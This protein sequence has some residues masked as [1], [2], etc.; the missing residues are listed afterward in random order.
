VAPK[1]GGQGETRPYRLPQRAR[2]RRTGSAARLSWYAGGTWE[3][4]LAPTRDS[5]P[6]GEP[7]GRRGGDAGN[8]AGHPVRGWRG[9]E[10]APPH[11]TRQRAACPGGSGLTSD[12]GTLPAGDTAADR[13]GN[14]SWC[15]L[16]HGGSLAGQQGAAGA[17]PGA[18]APR[19]SRAGDLGRQRGEGAR[20]TT[21]A[22]PRVLC[23]ESGGQPGDG[24]PRP[25]AP[26]GGWGP[27]GDAGAYSAGGA[28]PLPTGVSSPPVAP[29]G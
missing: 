6:E 15:G 11:S 14:P 5:Q 17:P 21:A 20:P 2:P 9:V 13:R 19:A 3:A 1:G 27:L 24:Q 25:M 7:R 8:S 10:H 18:S 16:P 4:R 29:G 26:W 22:A 23:Q 28:H 12:W